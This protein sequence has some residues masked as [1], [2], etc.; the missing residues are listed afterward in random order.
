MESVCSGA[1]DGKEVRA[2]DRGPG[3]GWGSVVRGGELAF[4]TD[5][6]ST[7]AASLCSECRMLLDASFM[8]VSKA[9]PVADVVIFCDSVDIS[10]TTSVLLLILL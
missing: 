9:F 1:V 10:L 3:C 6:D 8:S 2:W 4:A 5:D 7:S